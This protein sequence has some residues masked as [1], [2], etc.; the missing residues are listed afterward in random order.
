MVL[1]DSGPVRP[2]A[3]T[4]DISSSALE[5]ALTEELVRVHHA[6]TVILY[7]SRARGDATP[8]SDVDV[9]A[10][11][12]V[13]ETSRDARLWNGLYLDAFIHP[14]ALASETELDIMK[15]LGGR[16]LLDEQNLARPLLERLAELERRGPGP[17]PETERRMRRVWAEKTLARI[18]RGDL[19][20]H[21]RH[22]GM[23]F[24]LLEDYYALRTLWYPGPKL[25]FPDLLRRDPETYL[26]FERALAPGAP[27]GT[28]ATLV[29]RV[30]ASTASSA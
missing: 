27:L 3:K 6:H 5:Q 11:A 15:L 9:V 18:A 16:I 17:L 4:M 23:L 13:S 21:Y 29:A 19:E 1:A 10:F 26:A 28:L 30:S 8:E 25:A 12:E 20:A 14:T 22:H 24:Q 7:G 2:T